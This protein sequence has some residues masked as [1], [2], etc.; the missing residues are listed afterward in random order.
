MIS[1]ETVTVW[2]MVCVRGDHRSRSGESTIL[3]LPEVLLVDPGQPA[4][5]CLRG[6]VESLGS[7]LTGCH[8][9]S[10]NGVQRPSPR[11]PGRVAEDPGPLL[12]PAL[13]A[14]R[15]GRR[16]ALWKL[17][18]EGRFTDEGIYQV[19]FYRHNIG[20]SHSGEKLSMIYFLPKQVEM[21]T[22]GPWATKKNDG[23]LNKSFLS[24][25]V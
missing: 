21:L 13:S 2:G 25:P 18:G 1:P 7:E 19:E 4:S 10:A 11:W 9:G 12:A 16:S 14:C 8:L 15:R 6:G 5:D 17:P 24:P 20:P 23:F 3:S 22:K